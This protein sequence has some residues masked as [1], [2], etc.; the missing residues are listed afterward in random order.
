MRV[1]SFALPRAR[2]VWRL[3]PTYFSSCREFE[4][5]T[6]RQPF[7]LPSQER[8]R[9]LQWPKGQ[10]PN[11]HIPLGRKGREAKFNRLP[12]RRHLRKANNTH[13]RFKIERGS[14]RRI[15]LWFRKYPSNQYLF[16]SGWCD[17]IPARVV[18]SAVEHRR[19]GV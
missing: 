11:T 6:M 19:R 1:G 17:D 4:S 3:D 9:C 2:S 12:F 18:F 13:E 5:R 7:V 10:T 15:L 8:M 16:Q 14:A